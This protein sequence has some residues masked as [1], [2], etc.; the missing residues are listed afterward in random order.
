LG[1]TVE[2]GRS[3]AGALRCA[4][5]ADWAR[6]NGYCLII[7]PMSIMTG[8]FDPCGDQRKIAPAH[9]VQGGMTDSL[10]A[11]SSRQR[12][13]QFVAS[14]LFESDLYRHRIHRLPRY[15][16]IA[17]PTLLH[18]RYGT[19]TIPQGAALSL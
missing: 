17:R 6:A 14:C 10:L 11:R 2:N 8:G 9:R 15:S 16:N 7:A 4:L 5:K 19:A 18:H 13:V 3:T 12:L 1:S